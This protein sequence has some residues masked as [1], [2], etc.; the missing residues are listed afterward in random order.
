MAIDPN[1]GID[2][3]NPIS[4]LPISVNPNYN[5]PNYITPEQASQLRLYAN[6]LLHNAQTMP[7]KNWAQGLAQLANSGIGG[8]LSGKADQQQRQMLSESA[9][10]NSA[11][12]AIQQGLTGAGSYTPPSTSDINSA[13]QPPSPTPSASSGGNPVD[14]LLSNISN[15][16]ESGGDY[17]AVGPKTSSGDQA[18]GKYQ[19]MGANIP[20]W[21]SE[22]LGKSMTPQEFL[23]D[24]ASQEAVAHTKMSQYLSQTGNPQDAASMWFTGKPLAQGANAQDVNGMSGAKYAAVATAGMGGGANG[25]LTIDPNT[26]RDN[27][28]GIRGIRVENGVPVH[29]DTGAPVT[30]AETQASLRQ[31]TQQPFDTVQA[32]APT[33]RAAAPHSPTPLSPAGGPWVLGRDGSRITTD[34]SGKAVPGLS[35]PPVSVGNVPAGAVGLNVG[36]ASAAPPT[37]TP[38]MAPMQPVSGSVAQNIGAASGVGGG[39]PSPQPSPPGLAYAS[40]GQPP[41]L[42]AINSA[43]P[44]PAPSTPPIIQALRGNQPPTQGGNGA[45]PAMIAALRYP[46]VDPR[47]VGNALASPFVPQELKTSL[48]N[49]F[50]PQLQD[51][52]P[53]VKG[54]GSTLGMANGISPRPVMNPGVM[55][56]I[57]IAGVGSVPSYS[58]Y[59]PQTGTF[60]TGIMAP[61]E[62]GTGQPPVAA[63]PTGGVGRSPVPQV[64]PSTPGTTQNPN[65]TVSPPNNQTL[66]APNTFL[67]GMAQAANENAAARDQLEATRKNWADQYGQAQTNLNTA[68]GQG[69][70]LQ[71]LQAIIDKNGGKL[72]TGPGADDLAAV[73]SIGNLVATLTGH[74][75]SSEDGNDTSVQLF[76]KYG[77]QVASALASRF[78]QNPTNFDFSTIMKASPSTELGGP[79]NVHLIDNLSRLND[80]DQEYNQNLQ[81][82]Y[83][84]HGGDLSGFNDYFRHQIGQDDQDPLNPNARILS[85]FPVKSITRS[86]GS[87]IDKL[88][89]T[90]GSG[91][92]YRIRGTY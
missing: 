31:P 18:Y 46:G 42:A 23:S 13:N 80:L 14:T 75:I 51:I 32:Y 71:S 16:L 69:Y 47:L 82:Y 5:N 43:S 52:A 74:P 17:G 15:R 85:K 68:R 58:R 29:S 44:P 54:L 7:V 20:S 62:T 60:D 57:D 30:D 45:S 37:A 70:T 35:T 89:S 49:G 26:G 48:I 50:N 36:P 55:N 81:T 6:S 77:T 11:A 2:P 56:K 10:E 24:P 92:S 22:V 65:S 72:P 66:L 27:Y 1:T 64:A 34:R 78:N 4:A 87:T 33:P 91:Y 88:Q 73:Q 76:N 40:Q 25:P 9:N 61:G 28:G 90:N 67:G 8:Y 63:P 21:T 86:D 59:N 39:V 3:D 79:T 84:S 12:S 19:V 41:A 53:G 38:P 83:R